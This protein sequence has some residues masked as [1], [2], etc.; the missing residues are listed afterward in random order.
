LPAA[1]HRALEAGLR[2]VGVDLDSAQRSAI[3]GHVRLLLAWNRAI[4]LTAIRDPVEAAGAH[5]VDSLA[6]L[7]VF[8]ERKVDR[9]V[10][11][12][13]GG[14]FPG[15]PLAI[16]LPATHALLAD[17]IGKKVRFLE[18]VVD[19]VGLA[20]RV[21]TQTARAET[22]ARDPA[23]RERW[24]AVTARAVAALP[25]LVELAFP[26]LQ[27]GGV[28]V[29]WKRGEIGSELAAAGEP[30][31]RSAVARW[32]PALWRSRPWPAIALWSSA[33]AARRR[34]ASP[35]IP[36]YGDGARGEPERLLPFAR[37]RIAVLSDIHS[38]LV[39]LDAVL[40]HLG[41]VDA[42][43]QLGDVVGY[44]PD[45]DGVV[46]RLAEVGAVGSPGNHDAAAVGGSEIEW[47]NP[48]ART[49]IEWTRSRISATTRAWLEGLP[50][51]LVETDYTLV[52][53]SPREPLWEY[54]TSSPVARANLTFVTTRYAL[55]G[56][57]HLPIVW[58]E[59]DG[60]IVSI[61]PGDGSTFT[62][63]GRALLNPGSVGQ[64]RDG[65]PESSC[66][67]IDSDRDLVTWHRVPYDIEAVQA[68]MRDAGLPTRLV[69]RLS[70]GV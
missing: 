60:R 12:G 1:Y 56:H 2:E 54:I 15:L 58:A 68:A 5:V 47:F 67:V 40:A 43:W 3:D 41:S 18:T 29:A 14:G 57:T 16:A 9:F 52:H 45:P 23:H 42:I 4:N 37:M 10:D 62:L 51:R 59:E 64:P 31:P 19:A 70:Y 61:A 53:G 46:A 22:L 65:I 25:D 21:E 34:T 49:A 20:G 35:A 28:L 48:D 24:P 50:E 32:R 7:P 30:R 44:G 26:L 11:L 39:A 36:R 55:H 69:E 27:R 63:D 66:M 8:R 33:R 38:N 17:S 6:A 13:S